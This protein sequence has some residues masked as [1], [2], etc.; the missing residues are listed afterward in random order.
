MIQV[1]DERG[2]LNNLRVGGCS[3]LEATQQGHM[4]GLNDQVYY[5]GIQTNSGI[6]L[7]SLTCLAWLNLC[8]LS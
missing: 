5:R 4:L 2:N 1:R 3:N 7:H 6:N 8:N